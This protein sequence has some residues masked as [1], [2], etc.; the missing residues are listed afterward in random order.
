MRELI[1]TAR[2]DLCGSTLTDEPKGQGT[3][4]LATGTSEIRY[5]DLCDGCLV[6]PLAEALAYV[7]DGR[8]RPF[9]REQ[10][11]RDGTRPPQ[12][13]TRGPG[14]YERKA[15]QGPDLPCPHESCG[16]SWRGP[17]ALA[18]H[19]W[20]AHDNVRL[21]EAHPGYLASL[22]FGDGKPRKAKAKAQP[23]GQESIP[24]A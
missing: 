17:Q 8:G 9:D 6:R 24:G 18:M 22:G 13:P 16:L 21:S 11:K 23:E 5:V 19:Y 3:A 15:Y 20:K 7:L 14:V 12:R 10:A 2:C 4:G 1:L